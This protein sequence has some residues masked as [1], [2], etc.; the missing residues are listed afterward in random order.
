MLRGIRTASRNWFGKL[1][2]GLHAVTARGGDLSPLMGFARALLC[3]IFIPGLLW[4]IVS[5]RNASIQ[6]LILR[7]AVVYD[8]GLPPSQR[9]PGGA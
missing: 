6:D 4:V 5:R 8:W 2:M 1:V 9:H 7:T 3:L